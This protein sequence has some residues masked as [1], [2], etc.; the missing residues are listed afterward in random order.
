MVVL[1]SDYFQLFAINRVFASA[2]NHRRKEWERNF[3]HDDAIR[4]E[5]EREEEEREANSRDGNLYIDSLDIDSSDGETYG[6]HDS[7]EHHGIE[8]W[9]RWAGTP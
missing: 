8:F 1:Q 3:L 2:N 5:I 7:F 6:S 4:T 9:A